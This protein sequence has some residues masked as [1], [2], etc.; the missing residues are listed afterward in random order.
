MDLFDSMKNKNVLIQDVGLEPELQRFIEHNIYRRPEPPPTSVDSIDFFAPYFTTAAQEKIGIN[1]ISCYSP[2]LLILENITVEDVVKIFIQEREK[3]QK[4]FG[5][6]LVSKWESGVKFLTDN[7]KAVSTY[8][9]LG[10][11]IA[12]K[13][14]M[15]KRTPPSGP[16]N[17]NSVLSRNLIK[18][19]ADFCREAAQA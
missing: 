18:S 6:S 12:L 10:E 5:D 15:V 2:V 9:F 13:R 17:L 7:P 11:P 3:L 4:V 16:L 8:Y 14:P 19:M 1:G